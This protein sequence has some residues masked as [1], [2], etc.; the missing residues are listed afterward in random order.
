VLGRHTPCLEGHSST[1][2]AASH[3]GHC[4]RSLSRQTSVWTDRPLSKCLLWKFIT[5]SGSRP[6]V[7]H[8]NIHVIDHER[9][10]IFML[11]SLSCPKYCMLCLNFCPQF[12]ILYS[13]SSPSLCML[14]SFF[15]SHSACCLQSLV[16][17]MHAVLIF[18]SHILQNMYITS[19]RAYARACHNF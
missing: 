5:R 7:P 1:A 18:Q 8:D 15:A 14:C 10:Q 12:C 11:C 4:T 19:W 3:Q 9:H 16:Q 2:G 6:I 13:V 17:T